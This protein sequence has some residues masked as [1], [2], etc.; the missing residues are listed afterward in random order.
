MNLINIDTFKNANELNKFEELKFTNE[1]QELKDKL[2]K[3]YI[4]KIEKIQKIIN[5]KGISFDLLKIKAYLTNNK[6]NIKVNTTK[7]G[8]DAIIRN[9]LF[10]ALELKENVKEELNIPINYIEYMIIANSE[11]E[12]KNI[13]NSKSENFVIQQCLEDSSIY[14]IYEI[15]KSY[16][17]ILYSKE[18]KEYYIAVYS[19]KKID[20]KYKKYNFIDL[21]SILFGINCKEAIVEL[22]EL[23]NITILEVKEFV[24]FYKRNIQIIESE[25]SNYK[26][27][28]NFIRKQLKTLVEINKI[29]IIDCHFKNEIKSKE[30]VFFSQRYLAKAVNK[31]QSTIMPYVNGFC[32]LGFYT[33][34]LIEEDDFNGEKQT[35]I[36]KIQSITEEVLNNA[37]EIANILN[38]N[39]I[40]MSKINY[41]KVEKLFGEQVANN[42]FLDNDNI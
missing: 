20:G 27:L 10:K 12:A 25:I 14:T 18:R 5:T 26:Y 21:Y 28:N 31:S 6:L 11:I 17:K 9:N 13:V 37:N 24:Y 33:K 8:I 30:E 7:E 38:E 32:L 1:T 22:F 35:T 19:N 15:I 39:N 42:I 34:R 29:A 36:Y 3:D 41:K 16:Y 2:S 40:T 4:S 23:L